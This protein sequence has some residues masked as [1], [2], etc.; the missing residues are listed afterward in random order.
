MVIKGGYNIDGIN[1]HHLQNIIDILNMAKEYKIIDP[2]FLQFWGM[3]K[4]VNN[5]VTDAKNTIYDPVT[6]LLSR[7]SDRTFPLE[8][9]ELQGYNQKHGKDV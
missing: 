6:V 4:K 1:N 7:T 9:V 2:E 3:I 8:T 5:P